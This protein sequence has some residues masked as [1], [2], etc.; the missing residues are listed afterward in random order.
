MPEEI[1]ST[2]EPIEAEPVETEVVE[3]AEPVEAKEEEVTPEPE[4]TTGD[5]RTIPAHLREYFKS[6]E[7]KDA[8]SAWFERAAFREQFPDG[9]KQ[10]QEVMQILAE[11]GGREGI[12]DKFKELAGSVEELKQLDQMV[13][14]G[15]S[16]VLDRFIQ[17][18]PEGFV[19]LAPEVMSMFSRV[20]PEECNKMLC[21][22]IANTLKSSNFDNQ[23]DRAM[24]LLEV[25]RAEDAMK[26]LQGL[27]EWGG[28]YAQAAEAPS[29]PKQAPEVD[30]RVQELD[31][32]EAGMW[33]QSLNSR[34]GELGGSL[35]SKELEPFTKG[36]ELSDT[37]K[38][39]VMDGI[40]NRV[41]KALRSN[42]EFQTKIQTFVKQKD[43]E[44]ALKIY[45]SELMKIG[46]T[47]VASVA[48]EL[49]GSP[50]APP[51]KVAPK[52]IKPV[53]PAKP[54]NR[55]DEIWNS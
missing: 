47:I 6:P 7:G 43:T 12:G 51:P 21:G 22:V 30:K 37:K 42:T 35:I 8:K 29:K 25:G 2:P 4:E 48:R 28:S 17:E 23:I 14:S 20:A 3:A 39:L 5:H 11:Y 26:G 50:K 53:V 41:D 13:A 27:K 52:I 46:P 16:K 9:P 55:F 10:A 49:L 24:L 1:V 40:N 18:S 36:R 15:D 54:V 33:Q 32:R 31:Q 38:E 44:G 34:V 19:K 45:R